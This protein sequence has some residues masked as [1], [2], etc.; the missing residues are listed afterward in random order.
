MGT[1]AVQFEQVT[2][3]YPGAPSPALE[4]VTLSVLPGE[5]LGVLGPNGGG[6]STLLKLALGLLPVQQ[7]RI[8]V[9]GLTPAEARG[10]GLIGYVAQR[11]DAELGFP[12][13]VRQ[14]VE[15]AAG[16]RTPP[17][18]RLGGQARAR[19]DRALELTGASALADRPIGSLSGGQTQRA[20]IARALATDAKVLVLDEPLVGI[21]AA[22][23]QQ[24]AELL[25][26]VHRA[27]G[28]TILI[29]SHD[30]RAI[31]AGCDRVAC[32]ARR[33]HSHVS[34]QGLTPRVLA[35]LFSHDVAGLAGVGGLAGVHVHAHGPDEP[36]PEHGPTPGP[37]GLTVRG[38][39]TAGGGT[40]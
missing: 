24:F 4:G 36:C 10:R 16:W 5:R 1:E 19:V 20:M 28:V 39:G 14:V 15:L 17:W 22:G 32:L 7:G 27:T 33:L 18:R 2:Y 31:A 26:T 12:L 11:I 25:A 38:R 34:P 23:Q 9:F 40:P 13:S 37:V 3:R 30:L 6:K 21:D 35:E 8:G 29:V